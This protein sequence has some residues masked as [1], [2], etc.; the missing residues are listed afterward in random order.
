MPSLST[1]LSIAP[2]DWPAVGTALLCGSIIGVERQLSGKPIGIRTSTLIVLATYMFV[3]LSLHL[4]NSGNVDPTRT[5]GQVVTGVGFLGAGVIMT[6]DGAIMGITSAA[7]IWALAA[8]GVCI[9]AG[10]EATAIKLSFVVLF[11]L[12]TVHELEKTTSAL[13]RG[14][15]EHLEQRK[16][17]NGS[18]SP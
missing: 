9:A 10:H 5:I 3:A 7:A 17:R 2:F 1:L 14:V 6:R 18:G 12:Y 13:R 15:H 16:R 8:L 11:I 4:D